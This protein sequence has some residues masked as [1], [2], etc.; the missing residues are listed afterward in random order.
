M[1]IAYK[2]EARLELVEAARYYDFRQPGLG[3]EFL[4]EVDAA[5]EELSERPLRWR[6]VTGRFRRCLVRRFPYG[7]IYTTDRD[8]I[9]IFAFTHLHRKPGYWK[10]RDRPGRAEE[11]I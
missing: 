6:K 10:H 9:Q 7:I 4:K 8:N 2:A 5:L 3:N 1:G 11:D